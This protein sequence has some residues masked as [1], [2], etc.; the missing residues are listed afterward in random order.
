MELFYEATTLSGILTKLK[1]KPLIKAP[2]AAFS[3]T[4]SWVP[5]HSE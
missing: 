1:L 3:E 5:E 2:A 4:R